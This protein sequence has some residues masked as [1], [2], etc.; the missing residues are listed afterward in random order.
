LERSGAM[1]IRIKVK[2][3]AKLKDVLTYEEYNTEAETVEG[4]IRE[5]VAFNVEEY[6]EKRNREVLFLVSDEAAEVLSKNGKDW[7]GGVKDSAVLVSDETA[8][9]LLKS[10]KDWF[11]GGKDSAALVSDEA[12]EVLSKSGKVGFGGV[13]NKRKVDVR[14]MQDEAVFAF[15]NGRFKIINETK[16]REYRDLSESL[17]LDENDALVFIKLTLLSGRFF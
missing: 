15:E 10:G 16:R 17:D 2:N 13:E 8:E 14:I 7:F 1:K 6:N 11:G 3:I 4:L 9:V 5:A 12:A